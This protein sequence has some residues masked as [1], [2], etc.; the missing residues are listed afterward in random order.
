M[1]KA[2]EWAQRVEA[3]RASGKSAAEYCEKREY[4]AKS[5]QWWASRLRRRGLAASE[6]EATVTLARVVRSPHQA[7]HAAQGASIVVTLGE[8]RVEV[9]AGADRAALSMVLQALRDVQQVGRR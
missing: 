6:G 4:T 1:T 9:S 8:A 5:L 2:S 3:W 7:I